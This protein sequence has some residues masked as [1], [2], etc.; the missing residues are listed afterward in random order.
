MSRY[1]NLLLPW[2]ALPLIDPM[3]DKRLILV[4]AEAD[5]LRGQDRRREVIVVSAR[6]FVLIEAEVGKSHEVVAALKGIEGV[7]TADQVTGPYDVIAVVDRDKLDE[8]GSE[9]I[10][11]IQLIPGVSRVVSCFALNEAI[12]TD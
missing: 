9:L 12:K 8:I 6:V 2:Y 4:Y 1:P 11:T 5:T 10:E 3:V 7:T